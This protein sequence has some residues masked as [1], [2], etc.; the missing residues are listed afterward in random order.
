MELTNET[1]KQAKEELEAICKKYEITL[2]PVIVHQG[3]RT[4]SSIDLVPTAA[5]NPQSAAEP[6]IDQA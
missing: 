6:A 5:L 2:V 1:L 4:F 3:N